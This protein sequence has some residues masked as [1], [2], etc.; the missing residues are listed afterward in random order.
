MFC[1]GGEGCVHN[2]ATLSKFKFKFCLYSACQKPRNISNANL[3]LAYI[4]RL[5]ANYNLLDLSF[6]LR[7]QTTDSKVLFSLCKRDIV[8]CHQSLTAAVPPVSFVIFLFIMMSA[9]HI[10]EYKSYKNSTDSQALCYVYF[11]TCEKG[12]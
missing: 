2:T 4:L 11:E 3:M 9:R 5:C 10:L 1:G 8:Q 7:E 12:K 6:E